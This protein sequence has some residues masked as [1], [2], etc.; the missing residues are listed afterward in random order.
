MGF[1]KF[2]IAYLWAIVV[3]ASTVSAQDVGKITIST[4]PSGATVYLRGEF[5]I[6]ANTPATLP[7]NISGRYQAKIT[8]PGYE[9]WKGDLTFIPGS[10]NIIEI[11][12]SQKT[13][14][15]AAA[16]SIFIPGWGQVYSGNESRGYLITAGAVFTAVA[17]FQTDR[18]YDKKRADYDIARSNYYLASSAEDQIALKV[19]SDEKQNEAYKAETDR[20]TAMTIAAALWAYNV[21][22]ALI[23]FPEGNAYY[24]TVTA[25]NDGVAFSFNFEF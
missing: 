25:L 16:R 6:V 8:R 23:F 20:N 7:E 22:D 21:L 9:T 10:A 17:V 5:D 15:K 14:I 24:P 11:R 3:I 1:Y 12:L 19:I 18:R 2:M 13:R 4:N